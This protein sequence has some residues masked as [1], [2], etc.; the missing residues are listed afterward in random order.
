MGC[1]ISL[2]RATRQNQLSF[3]ENLNRWLIESGEPRHHGIPGLGSLWTPAPWSRSWKGAF[4]PD[5][6]PVNL[7]GLRLASSKIV[8]IGRIWPK[9]FYLISVLRLLAFCRVRNRKIWECLMG[10]RDV[11][12]CWIGD[13]KMRWEV[14]GDL[15]NFFFF[16]KKK[17]QQQRR[18]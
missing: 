5:G 14:D 3:W 13:T 18:V 9:T 17:Q 10:G 6:G 15:S 12:F 8:R 16:K 7:S 2:T 4:R 1:G 11:L